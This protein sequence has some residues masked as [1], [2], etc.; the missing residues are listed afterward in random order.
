MRKALLSQTLH[1]SNNEN[2]NQCTYLLLEIQGGK[3]ELSNN[4]ESIDEY[5]K[6]DG[7]CG[8]YTVTNTMRMFLS[9]LITAKM[10]IRP[11]YVTCVF[12]NELIV[13]NTLHD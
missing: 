12:I 8:V 3:L 7:G 6:R 2:E 5:Y 1:T 10:H 13:N 9:C 11:V 4:K